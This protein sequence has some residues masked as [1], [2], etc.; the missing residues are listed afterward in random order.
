[1]AYGVWRMA[2]GVWRLGAA[3]A[4]RH[5]QAAACPRTRAMSL[6]R[7]AVRNGA[8]DVGGRTRRVRRPPS[9]SESRASYEPT[10]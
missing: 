9:P 3:S 1:M 5:S 7:S 4:L 10:A 8:Y 6:Q 2:Y